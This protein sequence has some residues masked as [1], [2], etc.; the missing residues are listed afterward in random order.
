MAP[1]RSALT[2]LSM[3]QKVS[4]TVC[5]MAE[6]SIDIT[7]RRYHEGPIL[8]RGAPF[9]RGWLTAFEARPNLDLG[10]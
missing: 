10:N 1:T 8:F 5:M 9:N 3:T 6:S 4:A 2:R 7:S